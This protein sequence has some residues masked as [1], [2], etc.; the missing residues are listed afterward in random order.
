MRQMLIIVLIAVA[1][2]AP[3]VEQAQIP[4]S[5]NDTTTSDANQIGENER[6]LIGTYYRG[7]GTGY[8][9]ALTLKSTG[10]FNCRWTGCLGVYGSS[11]GTWKVDGDEIQISTLTA[12]GM[13]ED[14][15]IGT[16]KVSTN[17]G[18]TILIQNN[19]REFFDEHGPSRYSCFQATTPND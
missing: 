16:L 17:L 18:K 11:T 10:Q 15:P 4:E 6:Q 12:K 13:M 9:L 19:D 1:G 7:D 14:K 3:R 5:Q 8:N 2:C